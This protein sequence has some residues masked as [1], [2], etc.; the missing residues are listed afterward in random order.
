MSIIKIYEQEVSQELGL[1]LDDIKPNVERYTAAKKSAQT[2]RMEIIGKISEYR[3]Q[4]PQ[5]SAEHRALT[6][7][8]Y[9]EGWSQD[10]ID[11]NTKAYREQQRLL[12]TNVPEYM[13]L[14]EAA[15]PTQLKTLARGEDTTLAYDAAMHFKQTGEVPSKGKMEQHLRGYIGKK[16]ENRPRTELEARPEPIPTPK[17][18]PPKPVELTEDEKEMHRMGIR[19]EYFVNHVKGLINNSGLENIQNARQGMGHWMLSD[20]DLLAVV[21]ERLKDNES[22][23]VQ[24]REVLEHEQTQIVDVVAHE[25]DVFNNKVDSS[26]IRWRR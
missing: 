5:R 25:E 10:V 8:M 21:S 15:N 1:F 3:K 4:H 13:A 23:E 2:E 6:K 19:E 7:A 12:S 17:P 20:K 26:G 11:S 14:A 16:F 22:F 18:E 9:E 24:L